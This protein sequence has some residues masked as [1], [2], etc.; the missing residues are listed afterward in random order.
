MLHTI[1]G[2]NG[3]IS[4]E[5]VQILLQNNEQVRLVSRNPKAIAGT[6]TVAADATN[7]EEFLKAVKGSDVVYLLI[8]LDYNIKVWRKNGRQL[9]AM[10][11]MPVKY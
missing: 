9:C 4:N 5:L 10:Q 6:E 1:L 7:Y 2:A 3:S 11:L 8:G